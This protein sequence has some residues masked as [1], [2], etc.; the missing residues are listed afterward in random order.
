MFLHL[1]QISNRYFFKLNRNY[2]PHKPS[3]HNIKKTCLLKTNTKFISNISLE[4]ITKMRKKEH[5]NLSQINIKYSINKH[6]I[7]LISNIFYS[8]LYIF[9]LVLIETN[10]VWLYL[11]AYLFE[12][13]RIIRLLFPKCRNRIARFFHFVLACYEERR[14]TSYFESILGLFASSSRISSTSFAS[15]C[16]LD[17][18]KQIHLDYQCP[19]QYNFKVN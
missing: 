9:I 1:I 19:Y 4:E 5:D 10:I 12:L 11:S 17:E 15:S 2:S 8:S 18:N 16:K 3:I 6:S 14:N 7:K 13:K